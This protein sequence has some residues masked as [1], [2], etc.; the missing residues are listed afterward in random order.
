MGG[1]EPVEDRLVLLRLRL[2]G[3]AGHEED[4]GAGDVVE[5]GVGDEGQG[6]GVGA[7]RTGLGGHEGEVG[8]GEAGEHLVG[9]DGV[10]G[11]E[12]V[13]EQDGDVHGGGSWGPGQAARKRRRYSVGL[14]R[15]RRRKVRRMV[16]AVP[17]PAAAA[18]ALDAVVG[19]LEQPAGGLDAD[20]LDVAS[21]A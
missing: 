7:L 10:E 9:A 16:S 18:M 12:A 11:G 19:V 8:V 14:V 4:V 5:G 6:L 1:A 2:T 17:N 21:R 15:T 20:A 3:P 13:E